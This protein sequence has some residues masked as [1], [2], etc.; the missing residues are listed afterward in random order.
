[1]TARL[2]S[3]DAAADY[4]GVSRRHFDA[5][6]APRLTVLDV[7]APGAARRAP[8]VDVRDLDA[9]IDTLKAEA[10]A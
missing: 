6:F 1:M 3:L 9:L 5:V 7:A 8:R 2:L 10:V 4:C